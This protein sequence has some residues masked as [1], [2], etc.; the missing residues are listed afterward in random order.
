MTAY[1]TLPEDNISN[2]LMP[3]NIPNPVLDVVQEPLLPDIAPLSSQIAKNTDPFK[4]SSSDPLSFGNEHSLKYYMNKTNQKSISDKDKDA[5]YPLDASLGSKS[6]INP[7]KEAPE[8]SV[9]KD[10]SKKKATGL[11]NF[12]WLTTRDMAAYIKPKCKK[13]LHESFSIFRGTEIL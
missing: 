1:L 11:D 2:L 8:K 12:A 6:S 9:V 13:I 7:S 10:T 4:S 3:Q 5:D